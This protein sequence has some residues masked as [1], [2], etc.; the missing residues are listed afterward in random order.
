M[1]FGNSPS[2]TAT[3]LYMLITRRF[4]FRVVK[5]L[6]S[7]RHNGM[8]ITDES[9][10]CVSYSYMYTT[11]D[12]SRAWRHNYKFCLSKYTPFPNC[13]CPLISTLR[14]W[15]F[16]STCTLNIVNLVWVKIWGWWAYCLRIIP[17]ISKSF[18]DQLSQNFWWNGFNLSLQILLKRFEDIWNYFYLVSLVLSY[19]VIQRLTYR[20]PNSFFDG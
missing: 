4:F 6:A 1:L 15:I 5:S 14:L 7:S 18:Q 11:C 20:W 8:L 19:Y 17:L 9:S 10:N 2:P 13:Q 3:K 16:A 12:G